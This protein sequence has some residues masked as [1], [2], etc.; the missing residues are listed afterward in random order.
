MSDEDLHSII[1]YLRA[2]QGAARSVEQ[3]WPEPQYSFLAKALTR[4]AFRPA[5]LPE[6]PV[7][8]PP[9]SDQLAHGEYLADAVMDCFK[10]HSAS[11]MTNNDLLPRESEGYYGGGNQVPLP[12]GEVTIS[13]NLTQHPEHGLAD[14]TLEQFSAALRTGQRP[15]GTTFN[16]AMPNFSPL[17][18]EEIAAIWT[19]LQSVPIVDGEAAAMAEVK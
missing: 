16:G 7:V 6:G 8:A 19:Y 11:F 18:D 15:D 12:P 4:L 17:S 13:P 10:C 14:W 3:A 1:A 5:P 9:I 2:G